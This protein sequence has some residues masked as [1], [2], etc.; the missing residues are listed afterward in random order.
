MSDTNT[1]SDP[2]EEAPKFEER[3]GELQTIVGRLESGSLGLDEA[4]LQFE[5]GVAL[6]RTCFET[7]EQAEKR[8]ELLT[9]FDSE[10]RARTVPFDAKPTAESPSEQSATDPSSAAKR[11]GDLLF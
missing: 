1:Q 6:L 8:I 10:N 9:G 11:D 7:L 2:R 5:R 4:M 3:L